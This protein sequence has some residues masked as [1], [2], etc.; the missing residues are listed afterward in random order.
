MKK[1][2]YTIARMFILIATIVV[3]FFYFEINKKVNY[4]KIIEIKRGVPL[5]AS[6]SSLPVSDSFVFKVYLK[7]RNEGKG[8]KAGYYELKGE[9][10]MKDLIDVL[11][12]GKDKVFKLTIP[13]GYSIAEIADLLEK[14]GR[15]DKDKFYK[16]FNGI[17]FPYPTP[18]GNFEGYLYPET[19]YIPESYNERLIIRTLLREFL[20]KFPPEKYE[21]KDEFY[22]KLIMASILEREAKLDKEKPLMA[23]V[24]YNRIKKK[25]T[26]SS[27]ATVNFLYDYKKRRMYYKD[28]EI[29]SP[30]NTYKYKGLPPGPISNPSVVSVEAAYNPADTDYLFFVAT[31]DGGHFFSKTYK[32]H[33]E[34]QRKNKENK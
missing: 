1:W 23:S 18:E 26:L 2:I 19:Y 13:E 9:M 30:Y 14:N 33:L 31:G 24:F 12:A 22:Q 7:Y 8:I 27:D 11:E 28:L 16:E 29:D 5:K 25:M 4:H 10:S 21:D 17:E 32:E 6:L 3:V 34:F 15:I 20:K